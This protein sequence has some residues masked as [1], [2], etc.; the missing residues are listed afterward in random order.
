MITA[1]APGLGLTAT[2]SYDALTR[3]WVYT[4][5]S[6]A[7]YPQMDLNVPLYDVTAY[8]TAVRNRWIGTGDYA[9]DQPAR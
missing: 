5:G 6:G 2:L 1:F 8:Y 7:V 4:K 3:P 9:T